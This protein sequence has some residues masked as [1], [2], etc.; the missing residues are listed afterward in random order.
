MKKYTGAKVPTM[1]IIIVH[2]QVYSDRIEHVGKF[3]KLITHRKKKNL[4][5]N[6]IG[7]VAPSEPHSKNI[8]FKENSE[9]KCSWKFSKFFPTS[10]VLKNPANDFSSYCVYL[11]HTS[12]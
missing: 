3:Q 1:Q 4:S 6:Y 8:I 5:Q 2:L 9:Q 12:P 10:V 11:D 7:G